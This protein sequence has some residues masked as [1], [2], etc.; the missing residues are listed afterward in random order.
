[1]FQ[2]DG[3]LKMRDKKSLP[4][5]LVTNRHILFNG[6]VYFKTNS[7]A[8]SKMIWNAIMILIFY[9]Q[10]EKNNFNEKKVM[11][12]TES[13]IELLLNFKTKKRT[14]NQ[15]AWPRMYYYQSNKLHSFLYQFNLV[16]VLWKMNVGNFEFEISSTVL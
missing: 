15:S 16:H 3:F 4:F 10:L 1:M 7:I 14:L 11:M 6:S 9:T 5:V 12:L 2:V 13:Q 8:I